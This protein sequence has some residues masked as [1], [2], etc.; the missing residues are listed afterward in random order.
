MFGIYVSSKN[1]ETIAIVGSIL[2]TRNGENTPP[3]VWVTDDI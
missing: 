3:G 2:E 1:I